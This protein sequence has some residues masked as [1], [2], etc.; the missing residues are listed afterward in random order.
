MEKISCKEVAV[1]NDSFYEMIKARLA[2]AAID[3]KLFKQVVTSLSS[4]L[5]CQNFDTR[6]P[7][8]LILF[9]IKAQKNVEPD[10]FQDLPEISAYLRQVCLSTNVKETDDI[11]FALAK[12]VWLQK[13]HLNSYVTIN[14][15]L[16]LPIFRFKNYNDLLNHLVSKDTTSQLLEAGM[17][18]VDTT[19]RDVHFVN[20][21][22]L[23]LRFQIEWKVL[24]E[25]AADQDLTF[26]REWLIYKNNLGF[27]AHPRLINP[28]AWLDT[29][30]SFA[31]KKIEGKYTTFIDPVG[32]FVVI[33][34]H[35][36]TF[37]LKILKTYI[38]SAPPY[39]MSMLTA[40]QIVTTRESLPPAQLYYDRCQQYNILSSYI[41]KVPI[42]QWKEQYILWYQSLELDSLIQINEIGIVCDTTKNVHLKIFYSITNNSNEPIFYFGPKRRGV[43]IVFFTKFHQRIYSSKIKIEAGTTRQ[44]QMY[45]STGYYYP[46]NFNFLNLKYDI[47]AIDQIGKNAPLVEF[48][49][50]IKEKM[51]TL[52][53]NQIGK[54]FLG[55]WQIWPTTR[56][57]SFANGFT[58]TQYAGCLSP[59][60]LEKEP[61]S[62]QLLP[63]MSKV[64]YV[65]I[66]AIVVYITCLSIIILFT[67]Y[68][69]NKK[70]KD[71]ERLSQV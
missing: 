54:W 31:W 2:G 64:Y 36:C 17:Y 59:H 10:A 34:T 33:N 7:L 19:N 8:S 20:I 61:E 41:C 63:E 44:F 6:L 39:N 11:L 29:N 50:Q 57:E 38:V 15:H 55:N 24:L 47:G 27:L 52:N 60:S 70:A 26:S 9:T 65:L 21:D 3:L 4:I 18:F 71:Q 40:R 14:P 32:G 42:P 37:S 12:C 68:I 49:I 46:E 51:Y 13:V 56:L 66:I 69:T 28:P 62:I 43:I 22:F 67:Y 23:V 53:R 45:Q 5:K 25:W 1:L 16:F 35:Y 58:Q 30:L 48:N